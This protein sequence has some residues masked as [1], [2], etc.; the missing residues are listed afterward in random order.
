[1]AGELTLADGAVLPLVPETQTVRAAIVGRIPDLSLIDGLNPLVTDTRGSVELDAQ[2]A[3]TVLEPVITGELRVR[4]MATTMP[5]LGITIEDVELTARG[6]V[7]DGYSLDGSAR[8]GEG[9]LTVSGRIPPKLTPE[10]PLVVSL[11]G[12]RFTGVDTPEIHV[13]VTPDLE[14]VCDGARLDV[15]GTVDLPVVDVEMIEMPA[16]AVP[17]SADVIIVDAKKPAAAPPMDTWVDVKV[18]LGEQ[19]RFSGFAMSIDLEGG[20]EVKQHVPELP[21]CHGDVRIREG[22]YRAYGQNLDIER[23]IV[24]FVGPVDDPALDIKAFRETPDGV[25]AGVIITGSALAPHIKVYSEP[26]LSETQ[27]IS[28]LLTGR[29]LDAG[30]GDDK[31]NVAATAALLGSNVLSSQLGA[32]VGLDEARIET[33]GTMEEA[34]LVTG[35]YL[36]PELYLSY[37]MGLFDRSNLVRLRYIMSPKWAVQTETGTTMGADLFYKIERGGS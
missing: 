7:A 16:T 12:D 26:V 9:T 30:T 15:R 35:K 3:G 27:A 21:V 13:E 1:M 31:A 14:V 18:T 6:D 20:L 2:V 17:P 36:T 5:D 24:S 10:T 33:G 22:Y 32:K 4:G 19:V 29:P 25:I 34:A 37:A 23:G 28:Y 11:R 8:S